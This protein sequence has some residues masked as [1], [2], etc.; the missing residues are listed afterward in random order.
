MQLVKVGLI[1]P[2]AQICPQEPITQ[3][4]SI[5][6]EQTGTDLHYSEVEVLI[7]SAACIGDWGA[8]MLDANIWTGEL[9]PDTPHLELHW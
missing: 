5:I 7:S 1:S 2:T 8:G 4:L 3:S 6:N 9:H